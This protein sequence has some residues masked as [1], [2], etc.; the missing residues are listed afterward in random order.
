[1]A[2]FGSSLPDWRWDQEKGEARAASLVMA[3]GTKSWR[4]LGTWL[5]GGEDGL[6][7]YSALRLQMRE[8]RVPT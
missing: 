3:M 1:M 8:G 2:T 7:Q 5:G 6:S 4:P